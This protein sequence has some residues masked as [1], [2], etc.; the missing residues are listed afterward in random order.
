M[1]NALPLFVALGIGV[2]W[3]FVPLALI[4]MR[5]VGYERLKSLRAYLIVINLIVA[6]LLT[7]PEVLTQVVAAAALQAVYEVTLLLARYGERHE[8]NLGAT[9]V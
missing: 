4:A 1:H 5:T 3:A 6:A 8:K 2:V 9:S 7:T